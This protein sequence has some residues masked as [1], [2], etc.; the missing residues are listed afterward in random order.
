MQSPNKEGKVD[1]VLMHDTFHGGHAGCMP[2]PAFVASHTLELRA[3][4]QGNACFEFHSSPPVMHSNEAICTFL[5][6]I[7]RAACRCA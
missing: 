4:D 3:G 5:V 2:F 7:L 1:H 6:E